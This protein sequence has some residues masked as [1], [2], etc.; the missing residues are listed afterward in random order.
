MPKGA[1][2]PDFSVE[3][4]DNPAY[5]DYATSVAL[6]L[7]GILKKPPMEVAA[8]IK[9]Q[10]SKTKN[11]LF[12]K[13]DTVPPGFIN[14]WLTPELLQ[15]EIGGVLEKQKNYGAA[16]EKNGKIQVEFISANPTG[17]LTIGNGRGAFLGDALAN[18]LNF[19]GAAV[20]REYYVNDAKASTQ[21][22]ELGK[23]GVGE[24][25][26]Y[27]TPELEE[28][29]RKLKAKIAGF[30]KR[31]AENLYGEAGWLV[32][33][34][35]HKKNK[36]FIEKKLKI[37]F[38]V[39]LSENALYENG[40]TDAVL[41]KLRKENFV[42]KN[43]GALWLKTAL[44][45]DDEDHVIIRSSGDPTYFYS[46]LAAHINKLRRGF[47]KIIYIWGADH[48]GH[49]KRTEAAL[50]LFGVPSGVFEFII[51]QVV[52]L[53][54]GGME[55]KMS[56][57]RGEFVTLEELIDEVGA[58]AARFF[59]LMHSPGSHMDFD[60]ELAKERSAKNPV[61][62][63]Q[64]AHARIASILK[65][66]GEQKPD[67][68]NLHLLKEQEEAA[69]MKKIIQ[70][71]AAVEDTA[72]DYQVIRITRYATELARAFHNFYERHKVITDEKGLTEARL[73][74]V[75]AAQ[76]VL[77]NTLGL[78]GVSAPEEM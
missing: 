38:D 22:K 47:K 35:V 53:V 59:F 1:P 54:R 71:P 12:E 77:Q 34:E 50:K 52:R 6:V 44:G 15:K 68:K 42:Y 69:L 20:T 18:V 28:I 66:S 70:F 32:A 3:V 63:V 11:N 74:L 78:L 27:L 16:T 41:E 62:Y 21:I 48:H 19:A 57:R 75:L 37:K 65:K 40:E 30:Q 2:V 8:D 67:V 9:N 61:Y 24:G 43:E 56:K 13:I 25:T 51:M 14:F 5:G 46:D 55:I 45:G 33:Q 29:I 31:N 7:A 72:R 10:A 49:V 60:L 4:P 36:N 73:A 26:T 64:Y 76:I 39:W 23:T 58:D 17:E